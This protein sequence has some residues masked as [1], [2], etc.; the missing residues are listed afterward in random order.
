MELIFVVCG[1]LVLRSTKVAKEEEVDESTVTKLVKNRS[2]LSK[3]EL[4]ML[5]RVAE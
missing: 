4:R 3:M 5:G 2:G 1:W